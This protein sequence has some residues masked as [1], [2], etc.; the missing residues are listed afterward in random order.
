[1]RLSTVF[2]YVR[3]KNTAILYILTSGG[4]PKV[5]TFLTQTTFMKYLPSKKFFVILLLLVFL[6]GV[7]FFS[8]LRRENSLKKTA[9]FDAANPSRE[10]DIDTDGDGL[11]DWEEDLRHTDPKKPDT[12]GDGTQDGE[13]VSLG[14]SPLL[15]GPSDYLQR[16]DGF[17]VYAG[18]DTGVSAESLSETDKLMR[19]LITLAN[20]NR[21]TTDP[22]GVESA[23]QKN[24]IDNVNRR[25]QNLEPVYALSD[26]RTLPETEESLRAYGN[27]LGAVLKKYDS[28]KDEEDKVTFIIAKALKDR[29]SA[30]LA[31]LTPMEESNRKKASEILAI[32]VPNG[33]SVFHLSL[34]NHIE[35]TVPSMENMKYVIADTLR[36]FIGLKQYKTAAA[37]Q[38]E[39]L[40]KIENHLDTSGVFF[41]DEEDGTILP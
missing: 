5:A 4:K 18:Q 17:I 19:G 37:G 26:M 24:M 7:F 27:A 39:A 41:S 2:H 8:S 25:V 28:A 16:H 38:A 32:P 34:A 13:E 10:K 29:K 22:S 31:A 12:D 11:F 3:V 20:A 35:N 1:M 15:A 36:G 23:V 30:G 40:Q 21:N 14:R 6:A 9:L 33:L